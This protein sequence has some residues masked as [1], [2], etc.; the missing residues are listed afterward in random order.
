MKLA[1]LLALM[2]ME[3]T[4]DICGGNLKRFTGVVSD[5][6]FFYLSHNV[7]HVYT[8]KRDNDTLF[9]TVDDEEVY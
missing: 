8:T 3:N 5:V 1:E 4:V 6:P 9:I 2:D 7:L